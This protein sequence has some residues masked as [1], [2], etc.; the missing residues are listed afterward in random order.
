MRE[1]VALFGGQFEAG[2]RP[3]G[4]WSVRVRMPVEA[5]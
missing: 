3:S 2:P 4:G 1:R 5:T